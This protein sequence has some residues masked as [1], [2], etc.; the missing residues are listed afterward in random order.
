MD[1]YKIDLKYKYVLLIILA[2]IA[3]V[4]SSQITY[5]ASF[6]LIDYLRS[7]E[8]LV[9]ILWLGLASFIIWIFRRTIY[10]P[11]STVYLVILLFVTSLL[12]RIGFYWHKFYYIADLK[13]ENFELWLSIHISTSDYLVTDLETLY[14][15]YFLQ[16]MREI[17]SMDNL[18]HLFFDTFF[19]LVLSVIPLIMIKVSDEII[20]NGISR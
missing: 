3:G 11:L 20:G 19:F 15:R 13:K 5:L 6:D 10:N 18:I 8:G 7:L 4:I 9:Y 14:D 16:Y 2:L 12:F 17:F 1:I